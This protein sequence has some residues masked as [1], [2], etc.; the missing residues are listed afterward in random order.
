MEAWL[1]SR[2]SIVGPLPLFRPATRRPRVGSRLASSTQHLGKIEFTVKQGTS[3]SMQAA[4]FHILYGVTPSKFSSSASFMPS[5]SP[6][7]LQGGTQ[8]A[9]ELELPGH[10]QTGRGLAM[11]GEKL[12]KG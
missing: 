7:L 10:A 3:L 8:L 4:N 5:A 2:R 6:L 9:R 1:F 12:L 11:A